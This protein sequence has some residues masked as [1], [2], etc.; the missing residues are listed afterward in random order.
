MKFEKKF[1]RRNSEICALSQNMV[2]ISIIHSTV[3]SPDVYLV[4]V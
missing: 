3:Y 1:R 4:H 2:V